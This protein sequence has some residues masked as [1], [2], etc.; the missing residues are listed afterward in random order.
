MYDSI[1]VT[2]YIYAPVYPM[3]KALIS[4]SPL[5]VLRWKI[6]VEY[7][8]ATLEKCS[9]KCKGVCLDF[10]HLTMYAGHLL[11]Q[12][13]VVNFFLAEHLLQHDDVLYNNGCI[14]TT[15]WIN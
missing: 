7:M 4:L 12:A 9:E 14:T 15:Q 5:S 3:K 10:V 6:I 13:P 11:H 2:A 1:Y 8:C